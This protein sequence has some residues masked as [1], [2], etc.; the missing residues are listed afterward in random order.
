MQLL[1]DYEEFLAMG[2]AASVLDNQTL[3]V[4]Q[5]FVGRFLMTYTIRAIRVLEVTS[6]A[7]GPVGVRPGI[8]YLPFDLQRGHPLRSNNSVIYFAAFR[9]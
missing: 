4:M 8:Y 1:H 6:E 9:N 5:A 2:D 3:H 7:S